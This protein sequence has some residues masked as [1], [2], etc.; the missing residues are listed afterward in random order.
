M[1]LV[2]T[3]SL[4]ASATTPPP[5]T[6]TAPTSNTYDVQAGFHAG[7]EDALSQFLPNNAVTTHGCWCSKIADDVHLS[8]TVYDDLDNICRDW[9]QMRGCLYL[10]GGDCFNQEGQDAYTI[11]QDRTCFDASGDALNANACAQTACQVDAL[12]V[13]LI[14]NMINDGAS[15]TNIPVADPNN[16]CPA[17]AEASTFAQTCTGTYPDI[18]RGKVEYTEQIDV[19]IPDYN[20]EE[21]G[22]PSKEELTM[23]V[24]ANLTEGLH[25][26]VNG[27][28]CQ[29]LW[30]TSWVTSAIED[31]ASAV[32][33]ALDVVVEAAT[34][35]TITDISAVVSGIAEAINTSNDCIHT[36][37]SEGGIIYS[38]NYAG[39]SGDN[40]Y[41]N[42]QEC[43]YSFA[44]SSSQGTYKVEFFGDF[45][46]ET[47]GSSRGFNDCPYDYVEINGAKYC[48]EALPRA[49]ITSGSNLEINFHSDR[50]VTRRGFKLKFTELPVTSPAVPSGC[51]GSKF[52][53]AGQNFASVNYP[54][55]Y[56]NFASCTWQL[57]AETSFVQIDFNAFNIEYH[58]SCGY[59]YLSIGG[60]KYCGSSNPGPIY[61]EAGVELKFS[62]DYTLLYLKFF[63]VFKF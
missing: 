22:C 15:I 62:T 59:D 40:Y 32:S 16:A 4:L 44:H 37:T 49:I 10:E 11:N 1:K 7:R 38:P 58:S 48:G 19:Y 54:S 55:N 3:F 60:T 25:F 28:E 17:R 47:T 13:G 33:S 56:D 24:N 36:S 46:I 5:T 8:S 51:G 26:D 61:A 41:D 63:T 30:F 9:Q 53:A 34:S 23:M 2:S 20:W 43:D 27:V 52:P 42:N 31:V 14:N 12:H 50:S 21:N 39:P 18:R 6:S 57:N 29:S 35:G 45:D